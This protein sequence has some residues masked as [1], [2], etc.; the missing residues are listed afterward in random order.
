MKAGE[1]ASAHLYPHDLSPKDPYS[2][3]L[4]E[5][6]QTLSFLKLG[7]YE[8]CRGG[9]I[10]C[11]SPSTFAAVLRRCRERKIR[12]SHRINS[13]NCVFWVKEALAKLETDKKALG[14][15]VTEWQKVRDAAMTYCQSKKNQHRFDGKGDQDVGKVPTLDLIEGK[16]TVP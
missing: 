12:M 5:F 4:I 3:M 6:F 16:E 2:G 7:A 15:N 14:T 1:G 13:W 10:A 9:R 8:G 11:M